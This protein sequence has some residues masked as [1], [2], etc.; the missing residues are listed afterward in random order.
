VVYNTNS[1]PDVSVILI[2]SNSLLREGLAK[3]L[4]ST[5]FRV[6][7]SASSLE[8]IPS[9]L[10]S[11]SELI[12]IG[13]SDIA[14]ITRAIQDC[15]ERYPYAR[16]VVFGDHGVE[17]LVALLKAGAHACVG[18]GI[19]VEALITSLE[20]AMLGTSLICQPGAPVAPHPAKDHQREHRIS[21]SYGP[22]LDRVSHGLSEKEIPILGCLLQGDSNQVIA[23]KLQVPEATVKEHIKSI[24]HQLRAANRAQAAI[25]AM[26][27][28][29]SN[30]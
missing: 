30:T 8:A 29:Q 4:E 2:E 13:D 25:R 11:L 17:H 15:S 5:R 10:D 27:H 3:Y 28:Y 6:I 16:R 19:T 18:R 23:R 9:L 14:I 22:G 26:T 24:L 20:L 12:V 7:A 21:A 1:A